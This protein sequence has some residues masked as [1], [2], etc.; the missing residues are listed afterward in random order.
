MSN[1][2]AVNIDKMKRAAPFGPA[3]CCFLVDDFYFRPVV[4]G[5][6]GLSSSGGIMGESFC[7]YDPG[8]PLRI[9]FMIALAE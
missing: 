1:I 5:T 7:E 9:V 8:P 6:F 3:L 2:P 4:L